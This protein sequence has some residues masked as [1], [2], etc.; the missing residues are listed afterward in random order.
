MRTRPP[1]SSSSSSSRSKPQQPADVGVGQRSLV[2]QTF[3]A[4]ANTEGMT[5]GGVPVLMAP[6]HGKRKADSDAPEDPNKRAKKD[7]DGGGGNDGGSDVEMTGE[8]DGFPYRITSQIATIA[9][10][11]PASA[12][13]T[14]PY[15]PIGDH[16]RPGQAYVGS[17]L[18]AGQGKDKAPIAIANQYAAEAFDSP[19][20]ARER[21]ALVVGVNQMD[22]VTQPQ[23][24][25]QNALA[26]QAAQIGGVQ[27]FPATAFHQLWQPVWVTTEGAPANIEDVRTAAETHTEEARGEE[28][29]VAKPDILPVGPLRTAVLRQTHDPVTALNQRF[30][31]VYVHVGDGD[32]VNLKAKAT[33][34][35][36]ER[37]LFN[38]YDDVLGDARDRNGGQAPMLATGGY[39]F[40]VDNRFVPD[41]E[42]NADPHAGDA[43]K[44]TPQTA[45]TAEL[46]MRIRQGVGTINPSVPYMPEPNLL[47]HSS[48]S[49]LETTNFGTG[50]NDESRKL[51]E[52][53]MGRKPQAADARRD[54]AFDTRAALYTDGGRFD[55]ATIKSA[56]GAAHG[57]TTV[58]GLFNG[59]QANAS[60]RTITGGA[61]QKTM[62]TKYSDKI[63]DVAKVYMPSDL[64]KETAGD[65]A[66]LDDPQILAQARPYLAQFTTAVNA[67]D[68]A[69]H[70]AFEMANMNADTQAVTNELNALPAVQVG[71][72]SQAVFGD[73][74]TLKDA[75]V[76]YAG[77]LRSYRDKEAARLTKAPERRP[78]DVARPEAEQRIKDILAM[79]KAA[80]IEI[81]KFLHDFHPQ[82]AQPHL[83]QPQPAQPPPTQ[84]STS[85]PAHEP[86][87][88][89]VDHPTV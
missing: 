56:P 16:K 49:E 31:D 64:L 88:M 43:G 32:A 26:A 8:E 78:R 55:R 18:T 60:R 79:C 3:G 42:H 22:S 34:A 24:T 37:G 39:R 63:F 44:V 85:A 25:Q 15:A 66:S 82:A 45:A 50:N 76:K 77:S 40:R 48:K 11:P 4:P 59:P 81:A 9:P 87:A 65:A 70:R 86:N 7:G 84:P 69:M 58:S 38:R 10:G 51:T 72:V 27:A 17:V 23:L 53:V 41:A 68:A 75:L 19:A 62:A 83:A 61:W 52:S 46:S 67:I 20:D 80:G 74:A 35:D 71:Q 57:E 30:N 12:H 6:S 28:A 54:M 21:F 89:Q 5:S 36:P 2:Q 13:N 14:V 29:R 1:A 47:I 73:Q 33:P